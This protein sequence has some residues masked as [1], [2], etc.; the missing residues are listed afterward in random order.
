MSTATSRMVFINLAVRDLAGSV[1][2]FRSLGFDFNPQFTDDNAAC[3][4]LSEQG[5]VMLL[6][7][8]F[9]QSF[10]RR[11][12]CN[13]STHSEALL[14]LSCTSRTEVDALLQKALAGGGSDTGFV[15]EHGFMYGRGFYDLD[16]HH[17]EL[18]WMDPSHVQ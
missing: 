12:P 15:Q 9:F 2:F 11:T 10:T 13:T 6:S 18:I 17:W 8:P 4:I 7:E 16:G 1:A 14:G 3:M 5:F